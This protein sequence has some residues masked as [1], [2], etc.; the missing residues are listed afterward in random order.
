MF[1]TTEPILQGRHYNAIRV[2]HATKDGKP[3]DKGYDQ[4]IEEALSKL[5]NR[6]TDLPADGVIGV[7]VST[8]IWG[9]GW[10]QI[11]VMGTAIKFY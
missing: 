4:A 9:E 1:L 5:T 11:T 3:S 6:A 10:C 7:H 8:S 2:I